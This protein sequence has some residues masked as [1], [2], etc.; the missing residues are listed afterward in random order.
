MSSR[1]YILLFS[2]TG[3]ILLFL[4]MNS[5]A[6][7]I[8]E[9]TAYDCRVTSDTIEHVFYFFPFILLFS[10][11]TF[12]MKDSAFLAWWKFAR[13]AVPVIFLCSFL[14]SLGF[15]HNPGGWFNIDMQIDLIAYFLLYSVFVIGSVVQVYRGYRKV[16]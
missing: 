12:K 2:V 10:L 11:I 8:C 6:V 15:H 13:V 7:G 1:Y 4:A 9:R 14:I 16:A 3:F 5:V